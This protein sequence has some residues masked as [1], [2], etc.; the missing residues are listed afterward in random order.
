MRIS[1]CLFFA[2]MTFSIQA[3]N[4]TG[5][6]KNAKTQLPMA[7]VHIGVVGKNMGTIS[8]DNGQFSIN[9]STAAEN[10]TLRISYLG[11]ENMDFRIGELSNQLNVNLIPQ[12]FEI[13]EV[14]IAASAKLTEQTMGFPKASKTTLGTNT[15]GWDGAEIA[16][17]LKHEGA[18]ATAKDFNFHLRFNSYDSILFR[19]NLYTVK[20]GLPHQS[21]LNENIFVRSKKKQKWISKDL[22]P[23]NIPIES[24]L[25]ASIEI[26]RTWPEDTSRNLFFTYSKAQKGKSFRR[27]SSQ[28]FFNEIHPAF[29][30]Y[31][32][33]MH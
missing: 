24:D 18:P 16:T 26:I 7:Y 1:L 3:Q 13:K 20:D 6:V 23:Y 5:I 32:T 9:L 19:I 8:D 10:D 33:T 30:F 28:A 29:A 2:L 17:L 12:S 14:T 4:L 11:F 27:P 31:L 15:P 25:I 21:I 22:R